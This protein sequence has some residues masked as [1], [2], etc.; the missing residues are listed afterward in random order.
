MQ[1]QCK[2]KTRQSRNYGAGNIGRDAKPDRASCLIYR[3]AELREQV[4]AKGEYE[5]DQRHDHGQP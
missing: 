1:P 5:G 4:E 2:I 3:C